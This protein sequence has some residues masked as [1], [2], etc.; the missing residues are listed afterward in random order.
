MK[1]KRPKKPKEEKNEP[2][3][4]YV[5]HNVYIIED[6][7]SVDGKP[8]KQKDEEPIK[9]RFDISNPKL[10]D[11]TTDKIIEDSDTKNNEY[12][13]DEII[14][15]KI[16]ETTDEKLD[17]KPDEKTKKV[18]EK[19]SGFKLSVEKINIK[20][21]IKPQ[22]LPILENTVKTIN[23]IV[24]H[25]YQFLKLY[26][27]NLYEKNY[28]FPKINETLIKLIGNII[29]EGEG[30]GRPFADIKLKKKLENFY[31]NH[32]KRTIFDIPQNRS[33]INRILVYE[34]IDI[35]KN[36]KNNISEHFI[37]HFNKFI[38]CYFNTKSEIKRIDRLNLSEEEKK[39]E[40]LKFW[41]HIN[42]IKNDLLAVGP[43]IKF[44]SNISYYK[45]IE[46]MRKDLIKKTKYTKNNYMYDLKK[47]PLDYLKPMIF[48]NK[49]LDLM[50][51]KLFHPIPLRTNIIPKF[52][53]L[54]THALIDIFWDENDESDHSKRY[55]IHNINESKDFIWNKCFKMDNKV[56]KRKKHKFGYM[57]KTNGVSCDLVFIKLDKDNNPIKQLPRQ[58]ADNK[59]D[60]PYF[61]K[62]EITD[63]IRKMRYVVIDPNYDDIIHCM[64]KKEADAV[65]E[66]LKDDNNKKKKS[67]NIF[68]RY[69]QNQRRVETRKKKYI[70]IRRKLRNKIRKNGKSIC[71]IESELSKY[72]SKICTFNGFKR[73]IKQKNK[74]NEQLFDH[75]SKYIYRKLQ[76]NSYINTKKSEI[77]MLRNFKEKY[78]N[79]KETIVIIGD[80]DKKENMKGKEPTIN[81][82]IR[83]L[84][85][86]YGYKTCQIN[87]FR[88]SLLCNKCEHKVENFH[89]R[90]SQKPKNKGEQILVWGL[91]RCTNISCSLIMN[92]DK[93]A[94]RN[95]YKIVESV[96]AG[97]GRPVNYRRETKTIIS[98]QLEKV[99][100][101]DKSKSIQHLGISTVS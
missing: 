30:S 43:N 17:E 75:Y 13:K 84:F 8:D 23:K 40:K 93:N 87:E 63:E 59:I 57:I 53:S 37:K 54:D 33:N 51:K 72:N 94:C 20:K 96:L 32:Y 89:W 1:P 48:I 52:I 34:E 61:E 35:I 3:L 65:V 71:D 76:L 19:L 69:T 36:I 64:S 9:R 11:K 78:G 6:L 83:K 62:V 60:D 25:V 55:M 46:S 80:F 31:K 99:C 38:N 97:N 47:N 24:V 29:C 100:T 41:K 68:F 27:L 44:T 92:R 79:T 15:I 77:K 7:D 22:Y 98:S 56:F 16:H 45:W 10:V 67:N 12:N 21:V 91:V 86:E 81:R 50:G 42:G 4:T 101:L 90:E 74:M 26:L 28:H 58:N 5:K 14:Y 39:L 82:K 70:Q 95:M 18:V 49:Q 85:R 73:Y 88:T 66:L 2:R